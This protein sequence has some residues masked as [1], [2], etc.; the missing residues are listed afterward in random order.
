MRRLKMNMHV[1]P[2]YFGQ[3]LVC[4][5]IMCLLQP[6]V[7]EETKSAT[8]T[9]PATSWASYRNGPLQQGVATC[10]LP[11]KLELLWSR[12]SP[13][14][15]LATAAIVGDHVY[16]GALSGELMCLK[17][18]TG[19]VVWTYKT[20]EDPGPNDFLPGFKSA[21]TVTKETI[22]IGDEDGIMHAVD[23]KSGAGLWKVTTDAEIVGGASLMD[24]K[25]LFGSHDSFLYCVN[26]KDGSV[27]WKFQTEA[28]VNC[29]PAIVDHFTFVAGCDQH[30]RVIDVNTGEQSKDMPLTSILIASPAIVDNM[31]YVGGYDGTFFAIDW[32]SEKTIWEYHNDKQR[33]EIRSSA[34]VTD[35]YVVFGARDRR[36]HCLNRQTGEPVWKFT[37]KSSVDSS[38]VIVGDRVFVGSSDRF[39]YGISLKT[40]KSFWKQS[41][42]GDVTAAPAVG[43]GCLIVGA[44]GSNGALFCFGAKKQ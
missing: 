30:L 9:V 37:A 22:F 15:F 19:E 8:K 7:A 28:Q 44:E 16:A 1:I 21:P 36:L 35:E 40:G 2:K 18:Q 5:L 23:R 4:A 14:G 38:P 42:K 10:E 24:D 39:L 32:K 3:L 31:L 34:A 17:R 43:E 11:E 25:V 41:L 6:C 33:S 27:V 20:L 26:S 13:D 12:P 29:A